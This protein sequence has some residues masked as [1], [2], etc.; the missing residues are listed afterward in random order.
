MLMKGTGSDL[1]IQTL[2]IISFLSDILP[3]KDGTLKHFQSL[4][5]H[6]DVN[7]SAWLETENICLL[8][9]VIISCG[10]KTEKDYILMNGLKSKISIST[11][12]Q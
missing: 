3:F 12:L 9:I 5:F 10:S 11:C 2:P 4:S 7:L 6:M 1:G 8:N